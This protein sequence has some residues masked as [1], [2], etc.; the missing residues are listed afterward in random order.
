[1]SSDFAR[2]R[3]NTATNLLDILSHSTKRNL[4]LSR[5]VGEEGLAT[6]KEE[7][8]P[9][10]IQLTSETSRR[11]RESDKDWC[12]PLQPQHVGFRLSSCGRDLLVW[13]WHRWFYMSL[14]FG[15][16]FALR[17]YPIPQFPIFDHILPISLSEFRNDSC[18]QKQS[19]SHPLVLNPLVL[20]RCGSTLCSPYHLSTMGV[21]VA[22][23][24]V[25]QI[26]R[27]ACQQKPKRSDGQ[28]YYRMR[29]VATQL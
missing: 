13:S 18:Y 3:F 11:A 27:I 6:M 16:Y 4:T 20:F 8:S 25:P 22:P 7:N 15:F 21:R 10:Q 29:S 19:G 28:H 9:D 14:L 23:L 12:S 26:L 17:R 2:S 5:S 24:F 1:M